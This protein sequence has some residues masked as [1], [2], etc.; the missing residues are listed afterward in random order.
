MRLSQVYINYSHSPY[1]IN[2]Q[3]DKKKL[4]SKLKIPFF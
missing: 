1:I 3:L 2:Q 4:K